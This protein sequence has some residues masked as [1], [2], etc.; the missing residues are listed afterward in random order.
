MYS[1]CLGQ[2]Q[3]CRLS[4]RGGKTIA[5]EVSAYSCDQTAHWGYGYFDV[6]ACGKY[7]AAV[8]YCNLDSG[9]IRFVGTNLGTP[10]NWYDKSG[11]FLGTGAFIDVKVPSTPSYFYGVLPSA[12]PGCIDTIFTDTVSDFRLNTVPNTPCVQFGNPIQL[13]TTVVGGIP[14]GTYNY[15]WN[16]NPEL[17]CTNC[18]NPIASPVDTTSYVV[19][20]TDKVGCF[21][22]DTVHVYEAPN[23]GPD[24][25]V[26]PLG[27]RPAQLH[28]SGP[29]NG[30]YHWYEGGT[31][32]TGSISD[33]HRLP[34]SAGCTTRCT[35]IHSVL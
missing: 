26:C 28:V 23:A 27:E 31:V 24:L 2:E 12:T 6:I 30:I 1:I 8:S 19:T 7:K 9:Y 4:I 25:K 17:S 34:R 15:Q 21:R 18:N 5:I 10:Y 32:H 3:H 20:V 22:K 16:N 35:Y 29:D 14:G 11:T 33:M 13:K